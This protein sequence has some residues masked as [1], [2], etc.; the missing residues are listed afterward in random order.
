M[1]ISSKINFEKF[2]AN[3]E[4]AHRENCFSKEA[5]QVALG[6]RMSDECVF[7]EL[8]VDGKPWGI[9]PREERIELNKRYNDLAEEIV[10]KRLLRENFP[11][12]DEIFPS[13]KQIGEVFG[14][15]YIYDGNTTWLEGSC[16]TIQ[17]L[18]KMLDN[19]DNMNIREFILP[20]N[21]DSEKRRIFERYGK[22]PSRF[23]GV[24]GP[25]TLATSIFGIENLLFLFYDEP[26]LY[27]R[28][29]QTIE[30]V[31]LEYIDIFDKEAEVQ[32]N[33]QGSFEF[34]DDDC[35]LL[36]PEMYE[37]FGYPVLK[38][39]FDKRC[40]NENDNRFQ[41][42]D[43]AMGH[44]L[45]ILSRLNLTGCNFGPTLTVSEIR[46][47]M[48]KTRIDGQLAPFTFMRNN[49]D[50]IIAEVKRDCEMAKK[51]D[52]RGLNVFTAGSIND[53]SL[54][55]SMR[56]VMYAIQEYGQY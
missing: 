44:L 11:M 41:H 31:I 40:P 17:E 56:S 33:A 2:W 36:T 27:K 35:N 18:E 1:T 48:P 4:I 51:D 8:S 46:A 28:F 15:E 29:S 20:Q 45:E 9:T 37:V 5:A 39:V 42:S 7:S 50:E 55:T 21:W 43:S 52:L 30:K 24:R 53:G 54:L 38:A 12:P 10:G 25:V 47:H 3:D 22:K 13:F 32:P 19:V 34:Y 49:Q 23:G 26:E 14:G 6:I 16:K